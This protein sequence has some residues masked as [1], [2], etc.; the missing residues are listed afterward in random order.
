MS[1]AQVDSGTSTETHEAEL[2][3]M[4]LE[5]IVLPVSD[6]DRAKSFYELLGWRLDAD[7]VT[8]DDFRVLEHWTFTCR[9]AGPDAVAEGV[10][11]QL[12]RAPVA[13]PRHERVPLARVTWT[14]TGR[15][16]VA[17]ASRSTPMRREIRSAVSS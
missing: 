3:D 4:K 12:T 8:G 14:P 9:V 11:E 10:V 1:S 15:P 2:A 5:A 7:F 6:V 17:P 16:R 13:G